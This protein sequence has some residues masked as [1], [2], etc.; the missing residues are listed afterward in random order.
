LVG[1]RVAGDTLPN[2][3]THYNFNLNLPAGSYW[4]RFG[5]ADNQFFFN[6]GVDNVALTTSSTPEPGTFMLFGSAMIGLG[7]VLRRK[8]NL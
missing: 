3:Y 5:E 6:Q 1:A 7:G 2:P 4:L 8:I